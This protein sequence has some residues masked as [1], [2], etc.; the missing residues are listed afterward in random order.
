MSEAH[1]KEGSVIVPYSIALVPF[2]LATPLLPPPFLGV[3]ALLRDLIHL[4]LPPIVDL[5]Q[6]LLE[7]KAKGPVYR[8]HFRYGRG[9]MGRGGA[10]RGGAGRAGVKRGTSSAFSS[11]ASS[12]F[13]V[14]FPENLYVVV[15][16]VCGVGWV[17]GAIGEGACGGK[18][19]SCC[20]SRRSRGL[21]SS[22][23]PV[24]ALLCGC[25]G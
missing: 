19:K 2:E 8:M 9:W 21:T 17:G 6:P 12:T 5:V 18:E 11:S 7:Q 4:A 25:A 20:S 16:C 14:F 15:L 3:L 1:G 10:G 23:L 22:T 24:V 13:F